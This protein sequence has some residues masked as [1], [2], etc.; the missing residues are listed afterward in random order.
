MKKTG[1]RLGTGVYKPTIFVKL[2]LIYIVITLVSFLLISALSSFIFQQRLQGDVNRNVSFMQTNI[3]RYIDIAHDYGWDRD[4]L[5]ASIALSTIHRDSVHLVYDASGKLL[6]RIGSPWE[7]AGRPSLA[8]SGENADWT[9]FNW[10]NPR[11]PRP[12]KAVISETDIGLVDQSIIRQALGGEPQNAEVTGSEGN[13][14]LL[15]ASPITLD[16]NVDE[17]VIVTLFGGYQR[18]IT[19]FTGPSMLSLLLAFP[20]AAIMFYYF[21]RRLTKPL[22]A[23]NQIALRFA[24]N[25]FRN[26]VAVSS[27][28]EIGQLG[29]TLNYMADELLS[30]DRMR[31]EFLANV[32]H[33]MRAP[34]ASINGFATALLD[35]T[36]PEERKPHYLNMMRESGQRMMKLV[37]DLLDVARIEGNQFPVE[38]VPFNLHEGIRQLAAHLEPLLLHYQIPL[39]VD[40]PRKDIWVI[41]DPYRIDQVLTNLL[42][43]AIYHSP[44]NTGITISCSLNECNEVVVSVSDQGSGM[45]QEQIQHMWDRFYKGDKARRARAGTGIGLSIV[46]HILD[47]H[48]SRI[49]VVSSPGQGTTISFTL[50]KLDYQ[51]I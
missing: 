50:K 9:T 33:D 6:Y 35:G 2:I 5:L 11:L 31:Q 24:K 7:K 4:T 40:S 41:A 23:M 15:Y 17:K 32:S 49:E 42:H 18:S 27:R 39:Q 10:A 51:A 14:L 19:L 37:E 26:R 45:S 13:R 1:S 34:L 44:P 28:D 3:I 21:S 29:H 25:D 22:K 46:K 38:P 20:F 30:L 48:D 36:I 8:A 43:N 47:K 16:S 12:E